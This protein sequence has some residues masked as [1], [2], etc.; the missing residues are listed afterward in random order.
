MKTIC[1]IGI[2]HLG[3]INAVGF[4]K[5]GYNVIGIDFDQEKVEN[6]NKGIPPLFEPGLEELQKEL[7]A[8][9]SILFSSDVSL[10]SS[11]DVVVIAFDSP[12]NERGEADITLIYEATQKAAPYLKENTPVVITSQ[13][14]LGSCEM[15]EKDIQSLSNE[16]KSG[17]IYVPENLKLGDAINRFLNPD[18][19]VLGSRKDL[20]VIAESIYEEFEC[21]KPTMDLRSAEMVKHALNTFL[22]TSITFINEIANL[23]D[24]LG[25]DAVAVGKALKLDTRIGKK[26]LLMPGLGFS[27]GTLYRDVMQLHKFSNECNYDGL[28]IKSIIS[29]NEGTFD[30]ILIKLEKRLGKLVNKSIG[31]M[32]LTYKPDTS[33]MR[34]SPALKLIDKLNDSGSKCFAYDPKADPK[35]VAA[36][37]SIFEREFN[38]FD[39]AKKSDALVL[40]TEW[41][42]F[43]DIDYFKLSNVMKTPILIDSKNFLNS[44]LLISAGFDYKGFGR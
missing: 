24:R 25:A 1:V 15:I 44:E 30:E 9:G 19:L 20:H 42:E 31:I 14:P 4:C 41:K 2:W 35:E 23:S 16:W 36:C 29:I 26:A 39:M 28:L 12:L 6:L 17:V 43:L 8:N 11:A 27:G 7:L 32:G 38:I 22:A 5:K 21:P 40:V 33:T 10:V 13:M 34:C 18:M 37:S 3:I